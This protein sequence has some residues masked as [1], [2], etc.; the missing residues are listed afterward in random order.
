MFAPVEEQWRVKVDP[1]KHK[2][3]HFLVFANCSLWASPCSFLYVRTY[4]RVHVCLYVCTCVCMF[5]CMY[6]CMYVC[7]YVCVYVCLY[8]CMCVRMFVCTYVC[9]YVCMYVRVFLCLHVCVYIRMF[10]C[11]YVCCVLHRQ[12]A[13]LVLLDG[14]STV[15][16]TYVRT[17]VTLA[18]LQLNKVLIYVNELIIICT[19]I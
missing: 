18:T 1:K 10:V 4:V 3:T 6:M 11:M 13:N 17:R 8:V 16:L 14:A 2:T 15:M 12:C 5:V 9:T 7:M 19:F